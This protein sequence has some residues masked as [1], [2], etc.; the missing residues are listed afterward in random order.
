MEE[1][2][3]PFILKLVES[4]VVML[5]LTVAYPA[6]CK[7]FATARRMGVMGWSWTIDNVECI[8]LLQLD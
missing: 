1:F 6:V 7:C 8:C 5:R 4:L 3:A 2:F